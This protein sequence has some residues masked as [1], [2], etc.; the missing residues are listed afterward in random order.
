MPCKYVCLKNPSR[1]YLKGETKG[2]SDIFIDR[3]PG[4]PDN[5]RPNGKGG[6]Y[7]VLISPRVASVIHK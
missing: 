7:I 5:V 3:L 4:L 2:K 6:F 1:Y